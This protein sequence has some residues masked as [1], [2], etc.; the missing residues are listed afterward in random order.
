MWAPQSLDG[1]RG[2]KFICIKK[3]YPWT[4]IRSMGDLEGIGGQ[5]RVLTVTEVNRLADGLLRDVTLWVEGEVYDL[6]SGYQGFGF[7]SLRDQESSLQCVAFRDFWNRISAWLKEGITVLA[8][9]SLGIYA[10]RGQ[11]RLNVYEAEESGVGKLRR[12]FQLL[13]EKLSQEGLFAEE[14]KK[15]LPPV[16]FRIGLVTSPEGAVLHDVLTT[17]QRRFPAARVFLRGARVQG[18]GAE[19]EIAEALRFFNEVAASFP[20]EVIILARGGGSLEDLHPFNTEVV[21]RAIRAS[22]I[23][24]VCGVGHEPDYTIADFA[25]DLRAATPTAAAQAVVPQMEDLLKGLRS[26]ATRLER[27]VSRRLERVASEMDRLAGRR[28]LSDADALLF[29]AYQELEEAHASLLRVMRGRLEKWGRELEE[30]GNR[31]VGLSRERREL[32]LRLQMWEEGVKRSARGQL[33][34]MEE[35]L[36]RRR[37]RLERLLLRGMER[38]EESWKRQALRVEGLSPLRPLARGYSIAYLE[39]SRKPLR[40]YRE[41]P[42]GGRLRLQLFRGLLRC[43]VEGGEAG[44]EAALPEVPS[45]D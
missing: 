4:I 42:E 18:E 33:A 34:R 5:Q 22:R 8:W 44:E 13:F 7:F 31:L 9:G 10:K 26:T 45:W 27:A 11:F 17:L 40:D 12:E 2:T 1:G 24:V 39:E 25:A 28:V 37:E 16:A 43:A 38:R 20:V 29:S 32:P 41:V 19:E 14:L 35:G 23:P 36:S 30:I 3:T 6:R 21:A 15:P